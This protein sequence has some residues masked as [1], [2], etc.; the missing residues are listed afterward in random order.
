M[1]SGAAIPKSRGVPGRK[2]LLIVLVLLLAVV[3]PSVFVPNLM[4]RP[5][6]PKLADL[7]T[8]P[9]FALVDA[10]GQPFTDEAL[11]GHP[12]IVDFVFTRCDTICPI[13]SM[14]M[15][16]I[17]EKTR[18]KRG[19]AIKLLSFTVDPAHDTPARLA[20]FAAKY[21]ANPL[22]W[23]FVTG[24]VEQ[25]RALVEGPF[26]NSMAVEGTATSGAPNI[27]HGGYFLLVDGDLKIR[28]A[29][30]SN[31]QDRL[32]QLLRDARYLARTQRSGYKFG[33]G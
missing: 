23:K 8:V 15:Q 3:I 30:D 13:L 20:A 27:A 24:P 21:R 2:V 33:G 19:E 6:P 16:R 26:M 32:D 17:E 10:E 31:D 29:Y 25:V 5:E 14:K 28:G 22:R 9:P 4:C 11:R 7:G 12:T 18:D 1:A